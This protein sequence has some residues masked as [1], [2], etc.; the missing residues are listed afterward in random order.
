M[1]SQYPDP[2]P[3]TP[4]PEVRAAVQGLLT[5]SDAFR[6]LPPTKQMEVARDTALIADVLAANPQAL[7]APSQ[8]MAG[9]PR[10]EADYE[11]TQAAVDAIGQDPFVAGA[12]REGA[13]VAQQFMQSVNFVDFV[14]GLIDGVFH[15]IVTSS[16]EQMEAYGRMVSDVSKSLSQFRD[17]NTTQDDGRDHLVEQFP[18]IFDIGM[19]DFGDSPTP[20][21]RMRDGV[22]ESSALAR[23]Q[24]SLGAGAEGGIESLDVSDPEAEAKL[25]TAARSHIATARQ[26][27]LATMVLMGINRIVVTSGKISAKILYDFQAQSNR[28]LSRSAQAMEYARDASGNLQTLTDVEGEYDS[29]GKTTRDYDSSYESGK[30][31]YTGKYD[32]DYYTKGKYKYSSKPVMTAQ[33]VAKEVQNDSLTAKASLAGQVEVNFKSDYLPLEK[34]ATPEMMAALQMR[35]KPIDHN[36]PVYEA[37]SAPPAAAPAAAAPPAAAPAH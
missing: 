23:V 14:S 31:N 10:S 33:S 20:K 11:D 4:R 30:S 26:Q 5:K 8:A 6:A 36:R 17:E 15:S 25:I 7:G 28:Q 34:M 2:P 27:L 13:E 29:G 16:I 24:Q 18:D 3:P 32:S 12:A 35:S 1:A 37:G 19:D 22:D 21:L 9:Q